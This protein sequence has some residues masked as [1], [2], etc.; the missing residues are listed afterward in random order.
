MYVDPRDIE[1]IAQ[2][3]D[4]VMHDADLRR[5]LSEAGRRRKDR[6]NWRKSAAALMDIVTTG[7][8]KRILC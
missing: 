7:S 6:F 4:T 5:R 8:P 1:D 3:I 2:K